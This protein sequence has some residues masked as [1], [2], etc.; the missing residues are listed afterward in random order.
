M[1]VCFRWVRL[2]RS[3]HLFIYAGQ[4]ACSVILNHTVNLGPPCRSTQNA[5]YGTIFLRFADCIGKTY[6]CNPHPPGLNILKLSIVQNLMDPS[7]GICLRHLWNVVSLFQVQLFGVQPVNKEHT[8]IKKIIKYNARQIY[9]Y[10][11]KKIVS[12]LWWVAYIK[13]RALEY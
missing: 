10:C 5:R 13:C 3:V 2:A 9:N 7:Y 1:K 4:T 11:L 6:M 12:S 8:L